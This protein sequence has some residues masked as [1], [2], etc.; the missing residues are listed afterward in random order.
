MLKENVLIIL[1]ALT[2]N[3]YTHRKGDLEIPFLKS[4]KG[5]FSIHKTYNSLYIRN[6]NTF[7]IVFDYD[8]EHDYDNLNS[9]ELLQLLTDAIY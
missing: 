5:T 3:S 9:T 7:E 1:G 8:A 2:L 4:N 6:E